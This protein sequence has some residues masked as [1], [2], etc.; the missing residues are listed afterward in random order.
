MASIRCPWLTDMLEHIVSG[1]TKR[2]DLDTL[3]PWNW[4]AEK[5]AEAASTA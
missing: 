4:A 5:A 3:L 2:L 1:R